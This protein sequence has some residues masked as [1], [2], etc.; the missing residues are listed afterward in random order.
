MTIKSLVTSLI[1]KFIVQENTVANSELK[2]VVY[3]YDDVISQLDDFVLELEFSATTNT[4]KN[5]GQTTFFAL[6][7]DLDKQLVSLLLPFHYGCQYNQNPI[8]VK[9]TRGTFNDLYENYIKKKKT[10]EFGIRV[11]PK[12][13]KM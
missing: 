4:T 6:H 2:T 3:I 7:F 13:I 12:A 11:K 10:C 5:S 8:T 9:I 1:K